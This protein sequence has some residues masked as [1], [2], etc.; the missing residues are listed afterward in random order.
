[1]TKISIN[2]VNN[3]LIKLFESVTVTNDKGEEESLFIIDNGKYID[4][5]YEYEDFERPSSGIWYAIHFLPTQP[6]QKELGANGMNNWTGIFQ[7]DVCTIK[8]IRTITPEYVVKDYF[9]NAYA[10]IAEVMKRGVIQDRV[11]ITG[12]GKSSA[13]DNGDYYSMPISV[14]WYANLSN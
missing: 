10:A 6:Y 9:D 2:D 8:S 13:I 11:H 1:M 7:I 3:I 5:N 12:I 4:I 14:Q